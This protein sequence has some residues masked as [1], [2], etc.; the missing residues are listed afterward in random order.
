MNENEPIFFSDSLIKINKFSIW[1]KRVFVV[2]NLHILNLQQKKGV[3]KFGLRKKI[4]IEHVAGITKSLA[5]DEMVI[6]IKKDFDYR[7]VYDK[8]DELI[9]CIN[10]AYISSLKKNLSIFGVK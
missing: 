6:H 2:T 8:K 4:K 5:S 7:L 10:M 3:N 9:D 1:Q